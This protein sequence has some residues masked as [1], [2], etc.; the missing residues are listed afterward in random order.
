M[1]DAVSAHVG[2]NRALRSAR[3]VSSW[4]DEPET[5]TATMTKIHNGAAAVAA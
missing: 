5:F 1:A 4:Q 2:L 3:D